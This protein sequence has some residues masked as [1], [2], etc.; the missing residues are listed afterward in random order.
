MVKTGRSSEARCRAALF[1]M[2][3]TLVRKDTASLYTRYRRDVGEATLRDA[4][5]VAFWAAQ[6][7]VGVIDAERVAKRA[8]ESFK[9]REERWL[10]ETCEDWFQRY[11]LPHV[12][13]AGRAA[14]RAHLAE[15][16]WVA[17]VTGATRYAAR[18]LARELNIPHML[19][20][21]L[22]VDSEGRFTG[23]FIEPLCYG[24]GKIELV[25]RMEAKHGFRLEEAT[26]Y[27]DSITDLP[28]LE[29]VRD[30]I[31]INPDSRLKRIAKKRGWRVEAW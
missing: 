1:D 6:Y 17:I 30:P 19:C 25:R 26:F 24:P 14:V 11:V 3:R 23:G 12:T 5:R 20:S 21:E 10:I 9:G 27:S 13:D 29:I 16:D 22:D 4:L 28:L 8:L 2:D 31:V 15:G 7:S 18:P